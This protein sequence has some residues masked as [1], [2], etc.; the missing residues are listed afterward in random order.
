[1]SHSCYPTPG[2]V[3]SSKLRR[4][5][6]ITKAPLVDLRSDPVLTA[7]IRT[8]LAPSYE[9]AGPVLARELENNTD[10]YLLR[11]ASGRLQAL[12]MVGWEKPGRVAGQPVVYLGLSACREEN[13]GRGLTIRLYRQFNRD[14]AAWEAAEGER[15]L[16][17]A[18]TAHPL[19]VAV[20]HR[21]FE[22]LAPKTDGSVP[23]EAAAL[24]EDLRGRLPA[25]YR[26]DPHPLILRGVATCTR[27]SA[28][29]SARL[30]AARA[31]LERDLFREWDVDERRG[32]RLLLLGRVPRD[33]TK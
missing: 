4:V 18:T 11:D 12:F 33:A 26:T 20:S 27:Y 17:W 10:A 13:K 7:E 8:L 1:V 16:L 2:G 30:E 6:Q 25:E 15:L 5:V 24:A 28:S 32:D 3:S 22:V 29:E 23:D 31:Q 19:I 14:G 9:D 21:F